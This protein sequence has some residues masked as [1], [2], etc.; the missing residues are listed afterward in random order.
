[1]VHRPAQPSAAGRLPFTST[2]RE[3]VSSE[4]LRQLKSA[5]LAGRLKPGDKLPSEKQLAQQFQ[6]S[7]GSVREAIRALE[8]AGLLVVRPGAGGGATIS[9]GDLRHVTDSLSTLM[10]LGGVSIHHLTE[11]RLILEPRI[12]SLAAQRVTDAELAR[13]KAYIGKHADAIAA[14]RLHATADLGFHRMLAEAAKNPL[15]LL[16]AT[17]MADW[18]VEEVVARLQ[19]D[20]A[21]NR[22]NLAFHRRIYAA[23]ARRDQEGA[24]RL[25]LAHVTEVQDRLGRLLP[26]RGR[27]AAARAVP[28]R[29]T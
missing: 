19:M 15:L 9:D 21:T 8:Q 13:M 10:R 29:S 2:R 28:I 14:G 20:A 24:S 17:S 11:V 23:L 27:R 3:R 5:I 18:M 16:L 7:R 12:A 25:M 22:S 1:V 26:A 4:I 6:S